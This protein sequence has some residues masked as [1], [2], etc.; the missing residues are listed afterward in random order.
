MS[1]NHDVD[2]VL[3]G[4]SPELA[5]VIS[6]PPAFEP[7]AVRQ[8]NVSEQSSAK[9][10]AE[11][12]SRAQ[13]TSG[14]L[15]R[16]F[17]ALARAVPGADRVRVSKRMQNGTI[18]FVQEYRFR[19]IQHT[20]DVEVF[21]AQ[22]VQPVYKGGEYL[23]RIVDSTS[24]EWD[25]G[26]VYLLDAPQA[27]QQESTASMVRDLVQQL[28][29]APQED[30][31]EVMRRAQAFAKELKGG[32]G[33]DQTAMMMAMMMQRQNGPDPATLAVLE[34]LTSKIEKLEGAQ[35]SPMPM[36]PPMAAPGP[37]ITEIITAVTGAIAGL[38]TI[39]KPDH[40]PS[41]AMRPIELV[42]LVTNAQSQGA[43][44]ANAQN[45][46]LIA[47]LERRSQET[48][49]VASLEDEMEKMRKMTEFVRAF[50]PPQQSGSQTSFWD[51]MMA[52]ANNDRFASGIGDAIRERAKP[53][54]VQTSSRPAQQQQQP[55]QPQRALP[56]QAAAP[57][58]PP[59][60]FIPGSPQPEQAARDQEPA[61]QPA[62][63]SQ[64]QEP[65]QVFIPDSFKPFCERLDAAAAAEPSDDGI[66]A[67]RTIEALMEIYKLAQ[68]RPF[69]VDLLGSIAGGEQEKS[70]RGLGGWLGLLAKNDWIQRDSG[71]A[72]LRV[73]REQWDVVRAGVEGLL[74]EMGAD[75]TP[76]VR[77]PAQASE[78]APE[79]PAVAPP[80][81]VPDSFYEDPL[82]NS[83]QHSPV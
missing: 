26:S 41:D 16:K 77:P 33:G 79:A 67:T 10:S 9:K 43:S 22:Y 57:T 2:S 38:A 73:L 19:D 12:F 34:R 7:Q 59:P 35:A 31:L 5:G 39:L 49:P 75:P 76:A 66:I 56:Q 64:A 15:S 28:Q 60:S 14:G 48:T 83:Q 55:Q 45:D 47:L 54:H 40:G 62:Q 21:L 6:A 71:L 13:Q 68:F 27:S 70:M 82:A 78:T 63:A 24:K 72:A 3:S 4:L 69:V 42:Q 36:L 32:D 37:S 74:K 11:E 80:A 29:P 65:T 50:S 20:G 53:Q 58:T 61:A 30:P 44:A 81:D 1:V 17:G 51:A 52:F 25:A 18:A 46:R 8:P 23:L